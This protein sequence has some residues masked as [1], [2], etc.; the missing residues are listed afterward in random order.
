MTTVEAQPAAADASQVAG[1]GHG[2]HHGQTEYWIVG[3]TD[4]G[5]GDGVAGDAAGVAAP[6]AFRFSRLGPK[7]QALPR[8]LRRKV[9]D[10]MT[11]LGGRS[12][13]I[14]AGFTY[15]G[16][17]IDHDLTFDVSTVALG[18][19]MTVAE[20]EQARSP[21]LDLDCL[22]G[23]GPTSRGSKRFYRPDGQRLKMGTTAASGGGGKA[24]VDVPGFDLPRVV[25][26]GEF[27]LIPDRRNDENLAV[28]QT[29]LALIRFHN[30]VIARLTAKGVPV[31]RRFT[32]ARGL[33]VRHYQWMIR[34]DFLPRIVDPEIVDDVFEHGRKL[35]EVDAGPATMPTMPIEFSIGAYR[36]GHSMVRESY[37]WN[38]VFFGEL[39]S[40]DLLFNFSG[41][42]G[43]LGGGVRLPSNWI[44]DFRRLYDF[45]EAGRADL[46]SPSRDVNRAMRLDTHLVDPLAA[47]PP[48]VFGGSDSTPAIERNLAFRN[49]TRAE[50]LEL[51][52]GQQMVR[53]LRSKGV[54]VTRLG[55]A[56]I[57]RGRGGA[58]LTGLTEDERELLARHTPLWFYVL[59]EAETGDGRLRG[60]GG[61]IVAETFH[62]AMEGSV[63]SI[64][65]EPDW[66][67]SLGPNSRTF[68]MVDLLL[69]AFQ[70]RRA[71]LAP[72]GD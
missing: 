21:S 58:R 24:D 45:G 39:G 72:L 19:P 17:F 69:F 64:V 27:A 28:A 62:R 61:R 47:L 42:G 1:A 56:Q 26:P 5:D 22:Y 67:P 65:R 60:V 35:V 10:A 4:A 32:R 3:E 36:L 23:R 29:H 31:S 70:G 40:L 15:L 25:A 43:I 52:T 59:R 41:T 20:L 12:G 57:L 30:R 33:V 9:A 13:P 18:E 66:R 37:D 55:R 49:L 11:N 38:R 68:R 50:M 2:P 46:A 8:A 63:H 16:Q 7:G 51:A 71:L 14:P 6:P 53:L 44:A 34:T 54:P 48:S